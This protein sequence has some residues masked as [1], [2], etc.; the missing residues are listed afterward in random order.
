MR[1]AREIGGGHFLDLV[2]D[3]DGGVGVALHDL[4]D[5]STS[6]D[7]ADIWSAERGACVFRTR[8]TLKDLVTQLVANLHRIRLRD[9]DPTTGM[10]DQWPRTFPTAIHE[11]LEQQAVT[12][13]GYRPL[14]RVELDH[15]DPA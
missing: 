9:V 4:A 13:Y 7:A 15:E 8:T 2:L 12:R 11:R 14:T 3:P 6:T 1:W 5:S 10:T